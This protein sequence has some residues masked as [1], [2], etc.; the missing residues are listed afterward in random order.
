MCKKEQELQDIQ[1]KIMDIKIAGAKLLLKLTLAEFDKFKTTLTTLSSAVNETTDENL[2]QYLY[3][4]I[5]IE[6]LKPYVLVVGGIGSG[7]ST[8]IAGA[9]TW[10]NK[11]RYFSVGSLEVVPIKVRKH[12]DQII[13]IEILKHNEEDTIKYE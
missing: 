9:K 2:N 8:Y 3:F 1:N 4:N 11:R 6:T 5:P 7:K 13:K 10:D 12:A